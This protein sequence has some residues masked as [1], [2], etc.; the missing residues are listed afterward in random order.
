MTDIV[1]IP[2]D[3]ILKLQPAVSIGAKVVGAVAKRVP[4]VRRRQAELFIEMLIDLLGQDG[5]DLATRIE[6]DPRVARIVWDGISASA[7]AELE[8]HVRGL[9]RVASA[10]IRDT[11]LLDQ[12]Q[13]MLGLVA[14]LAA[15]HVQLLTLL[16]EAFQEDPKQY[17][18]SAQLLGTSEGVGFGL[19]AELLRLG[20][21]EAGGISFRGLH[22]QVR[23]ADLGREVLR[24][25][26]DSDW[27][28]EFGGGEND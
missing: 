20:L 19:N 17:P 11:A 13:Y 25:L 24:A 8:D 1:P 12:A 7:Q 6:N 5:K 16:E 14:Q 28:A 23:I 18:Q 21:V 3:E 26:Q 2:L 15:L 9:A 4:A 22:P 10:G 27:V